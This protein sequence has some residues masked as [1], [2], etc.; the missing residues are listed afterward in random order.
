[1]LPDSAARLDRAEL[2]VGCHRDGDLNR[3]YPRAGSPERADHRELLGRSHPKHAVHPLAPLARFGL[4]LVSQGVV[5][6]FSPY[7]TATLLQP[8]GHAESVTDVNGR[9]VLDE[10][11]QPKTELALVREQ[12]LAVGP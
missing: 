10:W 11:K 3:P 8:V 9:P 4:G 2:R 5:Q 7:Q 1:E 12:V 6:T